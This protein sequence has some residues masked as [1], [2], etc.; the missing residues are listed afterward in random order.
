MRISELQKKIK[1]K[2]ENK[3]KYFL[4]LSEEIGELADAIRRDKRMTDGCIKGTIEEE[5]YDSMYYILAIANAYEIDMEK[6]MELKEKYKLDK[7][8]K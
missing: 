2:P 1:G 4:K 5:L 3:H 7:K 6:A 8:N